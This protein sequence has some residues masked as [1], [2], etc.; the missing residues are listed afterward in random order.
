MWPNGRGSILA[1]V[2][3][4]AALIVIRLWVSMSS[5]AT[6][7][8]TLVTVAGMVVVLPAFPR[9]GIKLF[10]LSGRREERTERV[11]KRITERLRGAMGESPLPVVAAYPAPSPRSPLV[12]EIAGPVP[13]DAVRE[14]VL[15]LTQR[16]A[17]R[18]GHDIRVADRLEVQ[19]AV[20]RPAA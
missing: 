7:R 17:A 19:S 18:L 15:H 8:A 2:G 6:R 4:V 16:E 10:D 5:V 12:V 11:Q 9:V 13:T 1:A 20:D 14:Q 3:V